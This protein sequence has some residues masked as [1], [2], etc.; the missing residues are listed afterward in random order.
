[1]SRLSLAELLNEGIAALDYAKAQQEQLQ[2]YVAEGE[3]LQREDWARML[4]QKLAEYG[5]RH[6][7]Q[8]AIVAAAGYYR[9]LNNMTAKHAWHA[10]KQTPFETSDGKTVV[11]EG[12]RD[13]EIMRVKSPQ[14]NKRGGIKHPQWQKRYWPAAKG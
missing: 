9:G 11:I 7:L 1:M 4:R 12:N 14:G 5:R 3:R 2:G 8:P 13:N 10:I 6:G